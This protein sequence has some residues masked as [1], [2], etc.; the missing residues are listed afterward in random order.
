MKA[1]SQLVETIIL[2]SHLCLTVLVAFPREY[3]WWTLQGTLLPC[4][5]RCFPAPTTLRFTLP[6]L[7]T[8]M[9]SLRASVAP[10]C[11]IWWKVSPKWAI[12][13]CRY[14]VVFFCMLSR[15]SPF[16]NHGFLAAYFHIL[17]NPFLRKISFSWLSWLRIGKVVHQHLALTIIPSRL[18]LDSPSA[19]F[20]KLEPELFYTSFTPERNWRHNFLCIHRWNPCAPQ[21]LRCQFVP[22][23]T[24]FWLK[25]FSCIESTGFF[26]DQ[27]FLAPCPNF[28]QTGNLLSPL[29]FSR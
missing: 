7:K 24:I 9:S 17:F 16:P 14:N 19:R 11:H 5:C 8:L 3:E 21:N 29:G 27:H 25:S 10:P 12:C 4:C 1:L 28:L 22:A 26:F 20:S 18:S 23:S 13:E 15:E 2:A 6:F